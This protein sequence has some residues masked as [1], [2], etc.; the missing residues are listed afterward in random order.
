[1]RSTW[2]GARSGRSA[3]TTRPLVVSRTS[4][5]SG[6]VAISD[7]V[8]VRRRGAVSDA[9]RQLR[10]LLRQLVVDTL[11]VE[12]HAQDLLIGK[13]RAALAFDGRAIL[14]GDGTFEGVELA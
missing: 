3:I 6:S 2:P 1:M 14:L 4:V 9:L 10:R 13:C 8:R 7:P 5:F 12:V 11:D